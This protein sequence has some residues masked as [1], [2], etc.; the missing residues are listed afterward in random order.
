MV[1]VAPAFVLRAY[2]PSLAMASTRFPTPNSSTT[3]EMSGDPA[4]GG[5]QLA[6]PSVVTT[7]FPP[8]PPATPEA[9]FRY[10]QLKV[11]VLVVAA[12]KVA[13]PSVLRPTW[14]AANT[15]T[16]EPEPPTAVGGEA[17][18]RGTVE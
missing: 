8:T 11:P 4:A 5:A 7:S 9:P 2:T 10:T 3:S 18:G 13:P 1:Q 14:L 6:P 15:T 17:R 16:V 12:L